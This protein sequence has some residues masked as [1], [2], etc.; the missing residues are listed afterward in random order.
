MNNEALNEFQQYFSQQNWEAAQQV[1]Q[2]GIREDPSDWNALYLSGLI[3]RFQGDYYGAIALYLRALQINAEDAAIWHALGIAYQQLRDYPAALEALTRA[4]QLQPESYETHNSMGITYKLAGD[5][6]AAM[7]AYQRALEICADRAFGDLLG[8]PDRYFSVR[9]QADGR[10]F[11]LKPV[12]FTIMRQ[13]LATDFNYFNTIKNMASCCIAMG[14]HKRANELMGIA[15]TCTPI[16]ADLIGPIHRT[17][18]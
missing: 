1:V 6:G 11:S 13:T 5:Y 14:D 16:D 2:T 17:S 10:V 9:D 7:C 8:D 4:A 15:D 3:R 18:Q 12:Y